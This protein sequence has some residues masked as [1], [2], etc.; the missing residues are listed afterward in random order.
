MSEAIVVFV[1]APSRE[2]ADQ[3]AG[4]IVEERLAACV[5]VVGPITSVYRWQGE[6]ARDEELLLIAKTTR[7][8][9]AQLESRVRAEHPY[10]LPEIIALPV[11]AGLEPYLAW[12]RS[13][14]GSSES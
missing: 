9:F 6:V 4:M 11:V 8:R 7:V 5:N 3:L 12:V 2:V 13:E 10:E 1:T 14:T